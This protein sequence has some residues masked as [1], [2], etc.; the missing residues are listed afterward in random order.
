VR[1]GNYAKHLKFWFET[2]TE[3][4]TSD[5]NNNGIIDSI[6]DTTDL[7]DE[8]VKKGYDRSKAIRYVEIK[9]G[10]HDQET[11]STIMPDFLEWAFPVVK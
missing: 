2:G 11:W 8:L 7:M 9:G 6:E 10:K 4:E 1:K 5:R 3:D